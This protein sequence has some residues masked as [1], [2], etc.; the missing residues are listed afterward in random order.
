M[1]T[2]YQRKYLLTVGT[3]EIENL[4]ISFKV[5]KSLFKEPNT[6]DVKVFGLNETHRREL[7]GLKNQ[8]VKLEAGYEGAMPLLY[9]GEVR[10]VFTSREGTEWVTE[11]SSAEFE[12]K[13]AHQRIHK[14]YVKATPVISLF[15]DC[16]KELGLSLGRASTKILAGQLIGGGEK[17][18]HGVVVHGR[19]SDQL[20]RLCSSM[21]FTWSIQDGTLQILDID[22]TTEEQAV[23]LDSD[24]G[25]VG[26][27]VV[28]AD[29]DV[30]CKSLI[31]P[32]LVCGRKIQIEGLLV[33]KGFYR[34]D[35][36]EYTGESWSEEWYADIYGKAVKGAG[37]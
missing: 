33:T 16:A 15:Q 30:K 31:Q 5:S 11:L 27:P 19:A 17:Y 6:A 25:L 14:T 4:D 36:I 12:K 32:G 20:D 10:N 9:L 2:L 13:Q 23:V 28:D 26:S 35:K 21:G 7:N 37:Q 18:L 1:T 24:S 3:V 29:G 34:I 8:P 22:G